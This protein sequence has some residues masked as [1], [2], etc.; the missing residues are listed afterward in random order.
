[1]AFTV[2]IHVANEE[3]I[4]AEMEQLPSRTDTLL[5]ALNPRLRD[6]KDV[7]NLNEDVTTLIVPVW[8]LIF[9]QVLPSGREE[10]VVGFVRE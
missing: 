10:E 5:F 9:I 2:Q 4:V 7:R 1:M 6:G 8:R 3:P